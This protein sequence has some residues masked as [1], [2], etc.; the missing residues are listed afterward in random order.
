[1]DSNI[2]SSNAR[3]GEYI[4]PL[5]CLTFALET[6]S[7]IYALLSVTKPSNT[8]DFTHY[9]NTTLD[10]RSLLFF[11]AFYQRNGHIKFVIAFLLLKL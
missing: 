4:G 7:A 5:S 9:I 10:H 11:A 3:P 1:V 6:A 2:F 8:L